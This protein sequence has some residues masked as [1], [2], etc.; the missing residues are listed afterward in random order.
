MSCTQCNFN[1][2]CMYFD[3]DEPA[4]CPNAC[5]EEGYCKAD[6]DDDMGWCENYDSDWVCT[7]C[8]QDCNVEEC[9]CD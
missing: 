4:L 9:D 2:K 3:E 5:D 6:G 1:G 8:G 7:E